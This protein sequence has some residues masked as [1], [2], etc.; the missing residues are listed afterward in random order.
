MKETIYNPDLRLELGARCWREGYRPYL[1]HFEIEHLPR[2]DSSENPIINS[3]IR[4]GYSVHPT[5]TSCF[6]G[7]P[8]PRYELAGHFVSQ[9]RHEFQIDLGDKDGFLRFR[10]EAPGHVFLC[11]YYIEYEKQGSGLGRRYF[12]PVTDALFRAGVLSMWGEVSPSYY[13]SKRPMDTERLTWF[14][15]LEAG[16]EASGNG[17]VWKFS[18]Y[19]D[20][21]GGSAPGSAYSHATP[22]FSTLESASAS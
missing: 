15:V 12:R 8:T 10:F 9:V 16:F 2:F 3:L 1:S 17:R 19:V 6:L 22:T 18:P 20:W 7:F 4:D 14:Y 13:P 11:L 5:V 21:S